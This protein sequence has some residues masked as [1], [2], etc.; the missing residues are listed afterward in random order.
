MAGATDS[1]DAAGRYSLSVMAGTY[2]NITAGTNGGGVAVGVTG[3]AVAGGGVGDGEAV[4]AASGGE[5]V[6][7]HAAR[8]TRSPAQI[9]TDGRRACAC[10]AE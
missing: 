2:V 9:V 8:T 3:A 10:T 6:G 5:S 1:T 7:P 4:W